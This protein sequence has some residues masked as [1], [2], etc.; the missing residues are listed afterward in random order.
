MTETRNVSRWLLD[1]HDKRNGDATG[2]DL[3][4]AKRV[5]D[6][7]KGKKGEVGKTGNGSDAVDKSDSQR[8]GAAKRATS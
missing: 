2:N 5:W 7:K 4:E 3:Q 6:E 8:E 1:H